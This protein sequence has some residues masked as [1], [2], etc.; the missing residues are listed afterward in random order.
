MA[1]FDGDLIGAGLAYLLTGG[2]V[3]ADI[4]CIVVEWQRFS[5]VYRH[6]N[7]GYIG[8]FDTEATKEQD[9]KRANKYFTATIVCNKVFR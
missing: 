1:V 2:N 3:V 6:S 7:G 9:E 8:I 4:W 5:F